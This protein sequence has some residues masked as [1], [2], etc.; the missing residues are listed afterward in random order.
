M[1]APGSNHTAATEH[2]D[3]GVVVLHLLG[4][5]GCFDLAVILMLFVQKNPRVRIC[6][7]GGVPIL[8]LWARGFF[9]LFVCARRSGSQQRFLTCTIGNG[10]VFKLTQNGPKF[11]ACT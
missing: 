8:F 2:K 10:I 9:M 4:V 7:G 6:W 5:I 3:N 1:D 11:V